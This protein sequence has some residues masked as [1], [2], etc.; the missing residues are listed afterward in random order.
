MEPEIHRLDREAM[1]A[2]HRA[3]AERVQ[4][5]VDE[6]VATAAEKRRASFEQFFDHMR[7]K[8]ATRLEY[9]HFRTPAPADRAVDHTPS[10]PVVRRSG[11]KKDVEAGADPLSRAIGRR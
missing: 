8:A 1:L 3:V 6:A 11:A 10:L 4:R 2:E 5:E 7:V 9:E